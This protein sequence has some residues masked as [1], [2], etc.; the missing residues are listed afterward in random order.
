MASEDDANVN[1]I[2]RNYISFVLFFKGH[3]RF[4]KA[5]KKDPTKYKYFLW[6]ELSVI[7]TSYLCR[8]VF[9]QLNLYMYTALSFC[10]ASVMLTISEKSSWSW[11]RGRNSGRSLFRILEQRK[12]SVSSPTPGRPEVL[13]ET[14][15]F[16]RRSWEDARL[17]NYWIV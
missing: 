1:T 6:V 12:W 9:D 7:Q 14:D 11:E 15:L 5:S 10:I 2:C 17:A 3:M 4:L 8:T 13:L 16:R